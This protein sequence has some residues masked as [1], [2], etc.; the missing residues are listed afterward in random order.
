MPTHYVSD[1]E[2]VTGQKPE[3]APE[4][5]VITQKVVEPEEKPAPKKATAKAET[6]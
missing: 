1:Y 5:D 4:P 2:Q 3:D 6:K